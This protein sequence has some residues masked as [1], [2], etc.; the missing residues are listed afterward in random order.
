MS[1]MLL[2]GVVEVGDP[3]GPPD[4]GGVEQ[5]DPL[6]PNVRAVLLIPCHP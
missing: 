5:H 1:G 3:K 2:S 4:D 6:E